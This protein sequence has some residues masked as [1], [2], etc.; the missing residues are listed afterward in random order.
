MITVF[1]GKLPGNETDI[2]GNVLLK[3]FFKE[4][5]FCDVECLRI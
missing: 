3:R 2:D 5:G 4:K 1:L